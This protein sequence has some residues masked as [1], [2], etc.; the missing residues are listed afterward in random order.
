MSVDESWN[1]FVTEIWG[2]NITGSKPSF[3]THTLPTINDKYRKSF[4]THIEKNG[5]NATYSRFLSDPTIGNGFNIFIRRTKDGMNFTQEEQFKN[6][7]FY[8]I[9]NPFE[10]EISNS[11]DNNDIKKA[12]AEF[13]NTEPI[14]DFS[15]YHMWEC[16]MVF[17]PL[18]STSSASIS[19]LGGSDSSINSFL[20]CRKTVASKSASDGDELYVY[21]STPSITNSKIKK[22]PKGYNDKSVTD[23]SNFAKFAKKSDLVIGSFV[24]DEVPNVN[25]IE[26]KIFR[27]KLWE[28]VTAM[29]ITKTGGSLIIKFDEL[30][31]NVSVNIIELLGIFY[32]QVSIFKPYTSRPSLS[33][34]FIICKGFHGPNI[35]II[36]KIEALLSEMESR[37]NGDMFLYSIADDFSH[38]ESFRNM[39]NMSSIKLSNE[40]YDNINR[41]LRYKMSN[42][43]FGTQYHEYL[44]IQQSSADFWKNLFYPS[45]STNIKALVTNLKSIF[46]DTLILRNEELKLYS[47]RLLG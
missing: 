27:H 33:E 10:I 24:F 19:C 21:L 31:T 3:L 14:N 18:S 17:T 15:F 13:F 1:N 6:K 36:G 20:K 11:E 23:S 9:A 26:Q 47:E 43:Y 41:I 34:R 46:D 38:D 2:G 39:V 32:E 37:E 35:K 8:R 25:Y 29:K 42:N 44:G 16:M 4:L 30:Y 45:A 28:I 40:Q 22:F 12:T 5:F 7:K